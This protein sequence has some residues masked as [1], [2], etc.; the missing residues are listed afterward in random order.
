MAYWLFRTLFLGIFKLFFRFKVEGLNNI[1]QKTNFIIVSNHP[2]FLDPLCVMAAVPKRIY[3][4]AAR[5]L[6]RL[7]LVGWFLKKIEAFPTG[8]SSGKGVDLLLQNK[9]VGLFPEGGRSR[10]GGLREFRRGAALLA[11]RTGRP[12]LSCA[13]LGSGQALPRG[14][15]F[16]NLFTTIKVKVSKP[17]FILKETDDKINDIYLQEG[18]LRIRNT[19][20]E[21]IN[22]G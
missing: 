22:A 4:I 5:Y 18:M 17:I 1:P 15:K 10:Y 16:P 19:I 6:Y 13:I 9:N 7:P 20:E 8:S 14:A 21:M 2:S 12:I 11:A 3:C